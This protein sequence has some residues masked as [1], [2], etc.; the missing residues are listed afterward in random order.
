MNTLDLLLLAQRTRDLAFSKL[1][2]PGFAA[3][4]K[5]SRILLPTRLSGAEHISVGDRVLI[6]AGSWLIVPAQHAPGPNIVLHDRVRMNTTS[7]SAVSRVEIE[8]GV[9]IAR[10]CYI[11]DHS[12][13]FDDPDAHIRDQPIDRVAPVLIRRGAWLGQNC[14]VLP[15]VTI[16]R[17]SVIGAN[18]VVREDVPDR[19]VVAG[20]PARVLRELP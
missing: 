2:A 17:G 9:A 6:G 11:S 13:G 15:G 18:S 3:F 7:I 5:N 16:G 10:G 8:E 14:V 19:T 20:V 1:A 4:G 12:H